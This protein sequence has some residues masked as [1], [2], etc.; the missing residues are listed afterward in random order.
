MID[1]KEAEAIMEKAE[2][3]RAAQERIMREM[4]ETGVLYTRIKK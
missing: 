1:P 3:K 2:K 4:E